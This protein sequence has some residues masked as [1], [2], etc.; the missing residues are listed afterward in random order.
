MLINKRRD[1]DRAAYGN[2]VDLDIT[3]PK[4]TE[5]TTTELCSFGNLSYGGAFSDLFVFSRSMG[6]EDPRAEFQGEW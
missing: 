5:K 3:T 1:S 4:R 2:N 6:Y